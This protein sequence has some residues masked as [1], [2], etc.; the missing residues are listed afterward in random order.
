MAGNSLKAI[1]YNGE[2]Q[3]TDRK[4]NSLAQVRKFKKFT[5]NLPDLGFADQ[6]QTSTYRGDRELSS[7][8]MRK[9][10]IHKQEQM[11]MYKRK[12]YR[13]IEKINKL[14]DKQNLTKEEERSVKKLSKAISTSK[15][16]ISDFE[17]GIKIY[18]VEI[19]KKYA[20]AFACLV[21]VLVGAPIGMMTRTSGVGM[22]FS[23]SSVVFLIYYITLYMGE[24]LADRGYV[25]PWIAMW[26]ANIMLGVVGIF[27]IIFTVKESRFIDLNK[28]LLKVVNLFKRKKHAA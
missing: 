5:L 25:P 26:I 14:N 1:L 28:Y 12:M 20:I 27:L 17:R 4:D 7:A 21:F 15:S 2:M 19:H 3:F 23:V 13:N 24:E 8:A 22:A 11:E 10:I 6:D 18:Q 16:K 9:K